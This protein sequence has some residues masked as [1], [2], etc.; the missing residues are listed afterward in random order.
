V[1]LF[2]ERRSCGWRERPREP[3]DRPFGAR[4]YA[5]P[6]H[7]LGFRSRR[8]AHFGGYRSLRGKEQR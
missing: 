3:D 7:R 8:P 6:R 1:W 4:A 5:R 2:T